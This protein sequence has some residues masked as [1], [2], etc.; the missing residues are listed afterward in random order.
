MSRHNFFP[1]RSTTVATPKLC[2]DTK[3]P[4]L[5]KTLSRHKS[6]Y[7]DIR[8]AKSIAI[9]NPMRSVA[10][11]PSC[12]ARARARPLPYVEAHLL[13]RPLLYYHD[14]TTMLLRLFHMPKLFPSVGTT[15]VVKHCNTAEVQRSSPQGVVF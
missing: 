9:E 11:T 13:C 7:R 12:H 5:P 14:T 2:S 1:R 3:N 15:M 6:P 8:R 4:K 10:K